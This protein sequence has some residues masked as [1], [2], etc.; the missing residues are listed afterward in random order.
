MAER[1]YKL[2]HLNITDAKAARYTEQVTNIGGGI[3]VQSIIYDY[4]LVSNRRR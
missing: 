1:R 2:Q 4:G 3:Y